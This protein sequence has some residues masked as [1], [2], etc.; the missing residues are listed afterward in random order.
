MPTILLLYNINVTL[1]L[2]YSSNVTYRYI[3]AGITWLENGLEW[4]NGLWNGRWDMQ[5]DC[6]ILD[7]FIPSFQISEESLLSQVRLLA[8]YRA[9]S[10]KLIKND[11]CWHLTCQTWIPE[12]VTELVAKFGK[13]HTT[14]VYCCS[15]KETQLSSNATHA[16]AFH[17]QH[18]SQQF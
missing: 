15:G 2:S 8:N 11:F 12:K 13:W 6:C 4:C 7:S 17:W 16:Q 3:Y 10:R 9:L 5:M 18:T 1:I 14:K